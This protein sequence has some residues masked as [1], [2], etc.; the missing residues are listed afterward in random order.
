MKMLHRRNAATLVA[1]ATPRSRST[2]SAG[3]TKSSSGSSGL[4]SQAGLLPDA[5]QLLLRDE[6][7]HGVRRNAEVVRGEACPQT[8]DATRLHLLHGTVDGPLEGHLA[9]HWVGLHLLNLR[10]HP[11]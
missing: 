1:F 3:L 11:M 8:C 4:P 5:L 10:L 6:R 7:D 2:T 9:G